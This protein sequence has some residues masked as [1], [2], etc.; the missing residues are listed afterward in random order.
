MTEDKGEK[1]VIVAYKTSK[2]NHSRD[3]YSERQIDVIRDEV[4]PVYKLDKETTGIISPYR[5]QVTALQSA[6][7]GYEVDTVHKFQGREKDS[8]VISTVDD[9][10]SDFADDPNLINVAVSR[11]KKRLILVTSGND[12][13]SDGNVSALLDYIEYNNFESHESKIYSIFDYLYKQYSNER[14]AYFAK[15]KRVSEYDS[16]NLM[17][18]LLEDILSENKYKAYDFVLHYP[19]NL[20]L[21][22]K[23][24]HEKL[25]NL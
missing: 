22:Y 12:Q 1:D 18:N 20:V 14:A 17:N 8:I 10:I 4:I 21:V 7:D 6:L 19:I 13:K 3:K 25:N 5:N 9:D 11:A 15:H 23:Y 2:G 16:E 24:G